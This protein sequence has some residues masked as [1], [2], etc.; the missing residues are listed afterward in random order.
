ML[1]A[2]KVFG[3]N[4]SIP[5]YMKIPIPN[6]NNYKVKYVNSL[7]TESSTNSGNRELLHDVNRGKNSKALFRGRE[8]NRSWDITKFLTN[9]QGLEDDSVLT[10][11]SGEELF[12]ADRDKLKKYLG[13][14]NKGTKGQEVIYINPK[15]LKIEKNFN[16][17]DL[18]NVSSIVKGKLLE[19]KKKIKSAIINNNFKKKYKR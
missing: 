9:N 15:E 13:K 18:E 11:P 16:I 12:Y 17:E 1:Q 2:T 19:D 8:G 4:K 7:L 5:L 6:S 14:N 3:N 10:L